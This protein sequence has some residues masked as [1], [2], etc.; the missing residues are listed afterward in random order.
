MTKVEI[1]APAKVNLTLH[2]TGQ[3]EDGYHTLDSLV[4]FA[5]VYDT[6]TATI[7]PDL[8]LSIDGPNSHGIPTDDSNI[9]LK[10]AETL[11][12]SRNVIQG[13]AITLN[14]ALP[15]AAG[16][17]SG[18]SDAAA[19]LN[20]LADLWNVVPLDQDAPEVLRLGADVPVCLAAPT[21]MRMSG[22]GET[23]VAAPTLPDCALVLV[24][25]GDTVPTNEVF[26][27]LTT[28][29]NPPMGEIPVGM[30]IDS[31]A[32]WL[33]TQRNDLLPPARRIAPGIDA[34]LDRLNAMPKVRWA[35][36]SGSGATC[37]G[38]VENMADARQVARVMQVAEMSWWVAP[39]QVLR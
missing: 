21:P 14:K 27:S 37:I 23:L 31:F 25:P 36:L 16:L 17:G 5:D 24:N 4:V 2:V 11:R 34:A 12:R 13:A 6:I 35:G 22:I 10:A 1:R 3:N 30:D 39:A 32:A 8:R 20:A 15:H 18:S 33:G 26:Q 9:V 29:E 19:A 7:A 38:L 28:K